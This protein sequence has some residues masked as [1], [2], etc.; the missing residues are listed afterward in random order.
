MLKVPDR[1]PPVPQVS[2]TGP[3]LRRDR[4][5]RW[6]A[7][8]ARSRPA[9]S[10]ARPFMPRPT[11]SPGDLRRR[12]LAAHDRGHRRGRFRGREVFL[13]PKL[14]DQGWEHDHISRKLRRMRR[15]SLVSTDSGMKLHAV[16]RHR[17]MPQAHHQ[18]VFLGARRHLEIRGQRLLADDQ[19]VIA[20]GLKRCGQAGEHALA[21]VLDRRGL[22]VNRQRR[23]NHLAAE[24]EAD[25]LV[26]EAHAEQRH[27]RAE[28]L[29]HVERHAGLFGP[30]GPGRDHDA[31]RAPSA[32]QLFDRSP[33]RCGAPR[34]CAPSSPRYWT[35]L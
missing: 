3:R 15:P 10:A 32:A 17:A 29:D 9:R 34:P 27:P 20:A 13:A 14:L 8:S 25:R 1:S 31:R 35:R 19:R 22:A 2:N 23:A 12:R 28:L 18:P 30:S 33:R 11:S 26:A 24:G 6:R 21:V 5:P 7:S 16:N 4:A